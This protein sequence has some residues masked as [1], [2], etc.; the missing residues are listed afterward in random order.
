MFRKTF[1]FI[2]YLRV[3]FLVFILVSFLYQLGVSPIDLGRFVGAR[4]GSAVGMNTSVPENP[5]NR[6]AMQLKEKE[7]RL[8]ALEADLNERE[9]ALN[10]LDL[11]GQ[12]K[13]L[14]AMAAGIAI[15]FVLLVI[16]FY[17]DY[18]RRR[19]ERLTTVRK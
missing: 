3:Y 10:D 18:R 2:H 9:K 1:K 5:I 16:N 11:E 19:K 17:L 8:S 6:L 4:F 15:L 13:L 14:M 12:N 7:D